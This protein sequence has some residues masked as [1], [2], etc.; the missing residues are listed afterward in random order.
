MQGATPVRR[1]LAL[2]REPRQLMP[3]R[4]RVAVCAQHPRGEAIVEVRQLAGSDDLEQPELR[5]ARHQSDHLEQPPRRLVQQRDAREHGVANRLGQVAACG[6]EDLGD[7]EGV[8]ERQPVDRV[9]VG[10]ER[11]RE[12]THGVEGEPRHRQPHDAR[13]RRELAEHDAER[14]VARDLVVPVRGDDERVRAVDT[15]PEHAQD[16]ERGTVRPVHVLEHEHT[17]ASKGGARSRARV[18]G[19]EPEIEER[20]EGRRRGQVLARAAAHF[21]GRVGERPDER[22]LA[23]TGLAA[24]EDEPPAFPAK[25]FEPSQ[26]RL[27]LEQ[28][29]H[30]QRPAPSEI[31][32]R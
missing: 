24:D 32:R 1:Q 15:A 4:N 9:G 5:P 14:M 8:A 23:D 28:L 12:L 26:Q 11:R 2:D 27:P 22:R 6:G 3:E 17:A 19:L 18:A 21:T 29:G 25:L 20:P 30:G 31:V 16:V 13:R 7:E 10:I